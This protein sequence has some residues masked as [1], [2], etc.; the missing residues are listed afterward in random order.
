MENEY[1]CM[2]YSKESMKCN[3]RELSDIGPVGQT[4]TVNDG[5]GNIWG[6]TLHLF[7]CPDCKVVK[8][9]LPRN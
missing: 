1:I 3:G 2:N 5:R 4:M 6:G 9:M 7:Q 8:L